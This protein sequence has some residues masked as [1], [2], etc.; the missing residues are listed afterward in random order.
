MTESYLGFLNLSL[1]VSNCLRRA[2][3]FTIEDLVNKSE[4][5]L[6][7]LPNFGQTSLN[8]INDKLSHYGIAV[9]KQNTNSLIGLP[10]EYELDFLNLSVRATNCLINKQIYTI[11]DLQNKSEA[12][13]LALPNFGQTSLDEIKE[14]LSQYGY[15]LRRYQSIQNAESTTPFSL[16][17]KEPQTISE[18]LNLTDE[19]LRE[20]LSKGFDT[21]MQLSKTT[22]IDLL[23]VHEI[24]RETVSEIVDALELRKI[25]I[26]SGATLSDSIYLNR[27]GYTLNEIS[28]LTGVKVQMVNKYVQ[29]AMSLDQGK[30]Y[31]EI[32]TNF[33]VSREAVRVFTK[34]HFPEKSTKEFRQKKRIERQS[35]DKEKERKRKNSE[36]RNLLEEVGIEPKELISD[37]RSTFIVNETAKKFGIDVELLREFN[38][39]LDDPIDAEI[40][41]SSNTKFHSDEELLEYLRITYNVR[42]RIVTRSE[43]ELVAQQD[44]TE[45]P[46]PGY[47][48]YALRFGTWIN[49]CEKAQVPSRERREYEKLWTDENIFLEVKSFVNFCNKE[50]KKPT[51]KAYEE[52]VKTREAPS[53]ATVRKSRLGTWTAILAKAKSE[54]A[55]NNKE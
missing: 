46:W 23:K 18:T 7:A 28:S 49:A 9:R 17:K 24:N 50:D 16:Q 10:D 6:L 51:A 19:C 14:K 52:W 11:E 41:K 3:I 47:Q 4:A 32:A 29:T 30:S 37:L 53:L 44:R 54:I 39:T 34:R 36:L 25:H 5:E 38:S 43:Y 26:S 40:F 42:R 35:L 8:E 2:K 20:L 21:V 12:E 1:K 45:K 27:L 31:Q 48:T 22:I 33:G 55:N 13:L 15:S